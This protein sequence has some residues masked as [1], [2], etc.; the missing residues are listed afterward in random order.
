MAV[1]KVKKKKRS[2]W[3][4]QPNT[5]P[6]QEMLSKLSTSQ[7]KQ[8]SAYNQGMYVYNRHQHCIHTR[9]DGIMKLRIHR[10]PTRVLYRNLCQTQ[11]P[12]YKTRD[13]SYVETKRGKVCSSTLDY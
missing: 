3:R 4:D 13:S 8:H 12:T 1:H 10:P 6:T 11:R 2:I 7:D 9:A 5:H